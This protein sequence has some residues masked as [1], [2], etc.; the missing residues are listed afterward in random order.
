M[1]K[2]VIGPSHYSV[3]G[4]V[5]SA[6]NG[7]GR[8]A[9]SGLEQDFLLLLEFDR[10]VARYGVQPMT[11]HW[12]TDA[13]QK[14]QYTPDVL[15]IYHYAHLQ[16]VPLHPPTIFE[17]KPAAV[18]KRDWEKLRPKFKSAMKWAREYGFRF[19]II[20]DTQIRTPY[21][22]NVRFLTRFSERSL[23]RDESR[24]PVKHVALREALKKVSVSTPKELLR[25]VT[26]NEQQQ[27]ELIPMMWQMMHIGV[28]D[29]DLTKPLN[30]NTPIWY[31]SGYIND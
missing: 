13:G 8:D 6:K 1:P 14:R 7:S 24:D 22:N 15:V 11:V 10:A 5:P 21:L 30:M 19:K 23:T 3:T 9:E 12:Q 20:T 28:I 26:S 4:R 29:A 17:V 2:R 16:M 27:L 18:L 25:L 31:C